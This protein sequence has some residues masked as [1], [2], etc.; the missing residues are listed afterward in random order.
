MAVVQQPDAE[1][2]LDVRR[3][4]DEMY[5]AVAA[6]HRARFIDETMPAPVE[7]AEEWGD[8]RF[9]RLMGILDGFKT[10][11]SATGKPLCPTIQQREFLMLAVN[12]LLPAIYGSIFSIASERRRILQR[13]GFDEPKKML[14]IAMPRQFGKSTVLAMLAAAVVCAFPFHYIVTAQNVSLGKKF[15]REITKMVHVV[16]SMGL[17]MELPV[18]DTKRGGVEQ[19]FLLW[20]DGAESQIQRLTARRDAYVHAHSHLPPRRPGPSPG[21]HVSPPC[22]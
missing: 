21:Q 4:L 2:E 11:V 15:V 13:L 5:T 1:E 20:P 16:F 8:A 10:A 17:H 19:F 7:T 18:F 14:L 12:A 22:P 9:T 3:E 6:A